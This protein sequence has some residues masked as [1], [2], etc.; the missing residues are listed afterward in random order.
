LEKRLGK[1]EKKLQELETRAENCWK[2]IWELKR[3]KGS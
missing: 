2:E 3:K 1:I